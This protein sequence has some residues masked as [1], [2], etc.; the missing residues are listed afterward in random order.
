MTSRIG[1]LS[2]RSPLTYSNVEKSF[3]ILMGVN[4]GTMA[5]VANI[6]SARVRL[7][8]GSWRM[9]WFLSTHVTPILFLYITGTILWGLSLQAGR[10]IYG[11]QFASRRW[12]V[13]LYEF[14]L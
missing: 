5:E 14:A 10:D 13:R 3:P 11:L 9:T 1:L 12:L 6:A 2:P 7:V 8:A 4:I